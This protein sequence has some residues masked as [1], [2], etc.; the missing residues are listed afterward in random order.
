VTTLQ[1][2]PPPL[3]SSLS[4]P[5]SPSPLPTLDEL[6]VHHGT[7]KRVGIHAYTKWYE[8]LFS[9]LRHRPINFLEIGVQ[10]GGSIKMWAD[11]FPNARIVG[12]DIDPRCAQFAT[13]RVQII[14][15]SQ[16]NPEIAKYLAGEY[17]GGFD[18]II[19]DGSHV[20][21]HQIKSLELFFPLVRP[22]GAYVVEDLHCSYS[23]KFRGNSDKSIMEVLK[24][25]ADDVNLHGLTGVGD[26][27]LSEKQASEMRPLTI[28]EREIE[29]ITFLRSMAVIRRRAR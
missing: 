2:D 20:S 21:E 1:I 9:P 22:G 27:D 19:D 18:V 16:D 24:G 14:T 12:I 4:T 11:Y 15:G 29:S 23:P 17:A 3:S 8:A 26:Y 28:F 5:I 6:A 13:K 25:M 10:G 7:D